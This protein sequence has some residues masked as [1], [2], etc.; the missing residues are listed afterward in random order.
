MSHQKASLPKLSLGKK[1]IQQRELFFMSVPFVILVVIFNYIPIWGWIM[2]FQEYRPG[3]PFWQ[4]K[5]VGFKQFVE[6]LNDSRFYNSLYNTLGMSILGLLVGFTVPIIFALLINELRN[7]YFKKVVQTVSYLPHFVSW[8]VVGSIVYKM[9]STD[10]GPIN[11][12]LVALG[13]EPIQFMAKPELFWYIVTLSDLWKELGWNTIIYLAAI[14]AIDPVLYEAAKIDGAS[15]WRQMWHITLAGISSTVIVL[16]VLSIGSLIS[17]GFEKQMVLS[18]PVVY[19]SAQVL[20]LY[21][22]RYGL[23]SGGRYSYGT[24]VGVAKSVVSIILL[25][26]ANAIFKKRTGQSVM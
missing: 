14:T 24:A 19:D 1:I 21:A 15:R 18:N 17:I 3:I 23:G 5:W 8:V 7:V 16:I 20:D 25:F 12:I 11:Q 6:L 26:S 13:K 22:L 4:Q 2:A 9:L 10:G